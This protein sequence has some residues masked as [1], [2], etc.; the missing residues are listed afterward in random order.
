LRSVTGLNAILLG[1]K[2]RIQQSKSTK[3]AFGGPSIQDIL[4][5][6]LH[7][8]QAL[9]E[10]VDTVETIWKSIHRSSDAAPKQ[11]AIWQEFLGLIGGGKLLG[12]SAEAEDVINDLSTKTGRKHWVAD[13]NLY[14]LWLGRNISCW[15]NS[16]PNDAPILFKDCGGLLSKSF[17]L[18]HAG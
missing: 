11:K 10:G 6:L 17:R 16:L 8:L 12:T 13:G 1:L 18:G 7:V 9:L 2:Q 4:G 15:A 3:K 14:S 5:I